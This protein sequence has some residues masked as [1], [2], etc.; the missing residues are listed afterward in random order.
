M[1][2]IGSILA[3]LGLSLSLNAQLVADTAVQRNWTLRVQ[4]TVI[5]QYHFDFA[6]AYS[7]ANSLATSENVKASLTSTIYAG[8][9]LWKNAAFYI[10]PEVSGGSGLSKTLGMAGFTNGETF[11]VGSTNPKLYLAR[12]YLEQKFPLSGGTQLLEEDQNQLRQDEPKE[13]FAIR[14]GKFSVAD[15]FD[16][17]SYS[18]DPRTD[19][20]NWSLMSAAAWDYPANTRGY[21]TGLTLELKKTDW[22][23]RAALVQ[24]PEFAN[25]PVLDK[26]IDKA[27]GTVLE[28]EKRWNFANLQH[29]IIRA[30]LFYNK[31]RMGNYQQAIDS[32]ILLSKTPDVTTTRMY[33]RNKSGFYLNSEYDF[34]NGGVFLRYSWN[35]ASNETWAFTEIDRSFTLGCSFNG[36]AWHRSDDKWGVA[37][38]DNGLG[39]DHRSYLQHGG[40]GFMIGDGNLN[41]GREEILEVFY[42]YALLHHHLWV[43]PDYQFV[44]HPGYNK[45]RGPVNVVALRLHCEL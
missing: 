32:S 18:H 38:A 8:R 34:K 23:L 14:A 44:A 45:D 37:L 13:Y 10:N 9:R 17:N 33:S 36:N 25:G 1:K 43:S 29:W 20:M 15:F 12:A 31:A 11:R 28:G 24:V 30:G 19:F 27:Y 16:D 6:A 26:H 41:Y 2:H 42:S 39:K 40:Y 4:A 22:A 21:T 7:G 5:P 3:L 35:D